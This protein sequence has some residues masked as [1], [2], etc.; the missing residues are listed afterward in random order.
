MKLTA[1]QSKKA[2]K[3]RQAAIDKDEKINQMVQYTYE[4]KK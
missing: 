2:I 4:R 1:P 3:A